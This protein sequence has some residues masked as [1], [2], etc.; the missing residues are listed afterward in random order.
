LGK[1]NCHPNKFLW[2]M[3]ACVLVP[4]KREALQLFTKPVLDRPT[5]FFE[6]IQAS[7]FLPQQRE[8]PSASASVI[9]PIHREAT[10]RHCSR[11]SS[12]SSHFAALV[13]TE[14]GDAVASLNDT[15]YI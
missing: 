2:V 1:P 7:V 13:V 3:L 6:I 14:Q 5:M 8:V 12:G 4:R 15:L 10:S 9:V 11:R